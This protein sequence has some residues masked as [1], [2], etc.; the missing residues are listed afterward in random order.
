MPGR[1]LTYYIVIGGVWFLANIGFTV[2]LIFKLVISIITNGDD[3]NTLRK[4]TISLCIMGA[5]LYA[6][7]LLYF[8]FL[9]KR[10]IHFFE[11]LLFH[12]ELLVEAEADIWQI[13]YSKPVEV[14]IA[15]NNQNICAFKNGSC[16]SLCSNTYYN[17]I[18]EE[19]IKEPL[20][21]ER[22]YKCFQNKIMKGNIRAFRKS[23]DKAALQNILHESKAEPAKSDMIDCIICYENKIDCFILPCGHSGSCQK[24]CLSLLKSS[25]NCHLCRGVM[26]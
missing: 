15:N 11:Y 2:A 24:C 26:L 10:I 23:L 9:R 12:T 5:V 21:S 19:N 4:D 8:V 7:T 16:Y 13:R 20:H 25:G 3:S 1:R 17:L 6:C 18:S 14:E 22:E